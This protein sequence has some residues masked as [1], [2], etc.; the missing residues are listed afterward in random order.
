MAASASRIEG[1]P[2]SDDVPR[3]TPRPLPP[4]IHALVSK[5]KYQPPK[6]ASFPIDGLKVSPV[7][8]AGNT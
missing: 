3:V 2:V 7:T 1:K 4:K 8:L 5:G 6:V